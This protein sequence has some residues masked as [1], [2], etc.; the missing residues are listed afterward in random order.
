M[1]KQFKPAPLGSIVIIIT[2]ENVGQNSE[3]GP[4]L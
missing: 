1:M 4:N 3:T 2:S